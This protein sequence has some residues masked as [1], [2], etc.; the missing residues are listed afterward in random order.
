MSATALSEP[1]MSVK[2]Y[3]ASEELSVTKREYLGGAV[4]A[5]AG[6]SDSHNRIAFNLGRLL[7]N[8]LQGRR[9]EGFGSDMRL[10]LHRP[11]PDSVYFY[12]PDAMIVCNPTGLGDG[13]REQPAVL[14]E[15]ISESTRQIDEREKRSAY[16][17]I[18]S[19]EAYIRIEQSR[20]E[21]VVEFRTLEGWKRERMVGTDGVIRLPTLEIELSLAELY[22]RVIFGP[23]E[24]T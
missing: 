21:A 14:F 1:Y 7:G 23:E 24:T 6:A 2:E 22:E 3:L 17:Q 13:W 5:M 15:I 19:L 12:Y 8:Q 20:P 18:P 4:Y 10:R 9:C 16:L 11:S